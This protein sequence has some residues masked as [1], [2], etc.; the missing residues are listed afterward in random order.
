MDTL[1][2]PGGFSWI[3]ILFFI[4]ILIILCCCCFGFGFRNVDVAEV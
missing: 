2:F 4:I 3:F 1:G